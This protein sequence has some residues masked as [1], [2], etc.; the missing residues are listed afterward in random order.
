MMD[1]Q[2]IKML[3][4]LFIP[5]AILLAEGSRSFSGEKD[6]LLSGEYLGQD[7]PGLIPQVFAP[8]IVSTSLEELNAVFSPDGKEFYFCVKKG[9]MQY[10]V[11][12]MKR[13]NG[14]W[15]SPQ[16]A[17][18]SGRYSDVD[19]FYSLDGKRLYYSSNRPLRRGG[20]PKDFDI[21]F[22]EKNGSGWSD[23]KRFSSVINTQSDDFYIS[24]SKNG[25]VYY[26][27]RHEECYGGSDIYCSRL[28][29]GQYTK[30]QNLGSSVN[31]DW[32]DHDPFISSDESFL[33]FTSAD[34]SG[35]YGQGDLFISFRKKDGSW[36]KAKNMGVKINTPSYDY[37]P[38]IS[39]DGNFLFYTSKGDIYWVSSE[40]VER[41]KSD[42]GKSK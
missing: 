30:P 34:R 6:V 10:K 35:G 12:V 27:T 9:S 25:T 18:F 2:K 13:E 40:I 31:S 29:D 14:R 23:P 7:K 28:V 38:V 11:M 5:V 8:G 24:M 32:H 20:Y 39:P 16:S 19:P 17:S 42:T 37:C 33:L 41:M 21:W 22:V 26:S 1:K 4:L 3:C 36:T 15:N